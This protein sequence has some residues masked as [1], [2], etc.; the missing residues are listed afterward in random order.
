MQRPVTAKIEGSNPFQTANFPRWDLM[1]T[2]GY[3][4]APCPRCNDKSVDDY[5]L[6]GEYL[7]SG[8]C[9]H[10]CGHYMASNWWR[11]WRQVSMI[12]YERINGSMS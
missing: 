5:S 7:Y 10:C 2:S 11:V 12:E 3:Y 9:C 1:Y 8:V 4:G 6:T